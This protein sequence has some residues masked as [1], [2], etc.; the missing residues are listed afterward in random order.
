MEHSA[1]LVCFISTL[2]SRIKKRKKK[3]RKSGISSGHIINLKQ[4]IFVFRYL[5]LI[6]YLA[7][8]QKASVLNF[9]HRDS[10]ITHRE[11]TCTARA[12]HA[13]DQFA[14]V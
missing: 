13:Q 7:V 11:Q 2:N 1:C 4:S 14:L 6:Q 9:N 8:S 3:P 5:W 10:S 12:L